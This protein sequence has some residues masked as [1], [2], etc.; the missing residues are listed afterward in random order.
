MRSIDIGM[1]KVKR[2]KVKPKAQADKIALRAERRA[3]IKPHMI[4]PLRRPIQAEVAGEGS[5]F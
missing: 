2:R 1:N 3:K 4:P 5:M